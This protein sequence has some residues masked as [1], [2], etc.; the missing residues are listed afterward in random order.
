[1][2]YVRPVSKTTWYLANRSYTIHMINELTSLFVGIF[3]LILLW[4]IGAV[5]RGKEAYEA[6]LTNLKGPGM[7]ALLWVTTIVVFYHAI[8]WFKVTPKAMPIQR[9]EEFVPASVIAG[10]HYVA[11]I[12][13]SLVVL[14]LAG[15]F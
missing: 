5:S 1:M 8:A 2:P 7:V 12:V 15:V 6:F 13:L 14:I 4:G 9:G 10:A 3:A 11:W